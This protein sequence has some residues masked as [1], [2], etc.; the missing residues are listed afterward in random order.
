MEW[1]CNLNLQWSFGGIYERFILYLPLN[2]KLMQVMTRIFSIFNYFRRLH[3]TVE[4]VERRI[5]KKCLYFG[6]VYYSL[7]CR[8]TYDYKL[9]ASCWSANKE[10]RIKFGPSLACKIIF[11]KWGLGQFVF[12][13]KPCLTRSNCS[14]DFHCDHN[15]KP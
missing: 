11:L 4:L 8:P 2:I 5:T 10:F 15:R 13:R 7:Y 9:I 12:S 1:L 3:M 14:Y 6:I